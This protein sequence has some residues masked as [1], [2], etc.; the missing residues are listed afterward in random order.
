MDLINNV[1][2][3]E[4]LKYALP[5]YNLDYLTQSNNNIQFT[6]DDDTFLEAL[7]LQIR[8]ETIKY[9]SKFKREQNLK[10]NQLLKDIEDL[11][12]S[13]NART[14][15]DILEDKRLELESIQNEKI[16]G[17]MI[18]SRMQWLTEAE[19]PTS[20]FC[21]LENTNFVNK[22]IKKLNLTNDSI[23]TEQK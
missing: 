21:K 1:I 6:I 23:I 3:A 13:N 16:K 18:R 7:I 4:K 10:E 14:S 8:G 17:Q 22:T 20:Y 15:S 2:Q 9:S 5:V 19:K 11:Q 12:S